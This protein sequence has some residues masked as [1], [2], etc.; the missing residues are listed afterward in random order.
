MQSVDKQELFVNKIIP[1]VFISL[2]QC[3]GYNF[4]YE[5][6]FLE[7]RKRDIYDSKV[8]DSREFMQD[9]ADSMNLALN[10]LFS[11]NLKPQYI[12]PLHYVVLPYRSFD[13]AVE[14]YLSLEDDSKVIIEVYNKSG[15]LHRSESDRKSRLHTLL[16]LV[17]EYL[18]ECNTGLADITNGIA[19][20]EVTT[21]SLSSEIEDRYIGFS[22]IYELGEAMQGHL[23]DLIMENID[24]LQMKCSY[25]SEDCI[26]ISFADCPDD[27]VLCIM[28]NVVNYTFRAFIMLGDKYMDVV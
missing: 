21:V 9:I 25:I 19:S 22:W 1:D 24:R 14:Y 12:S 4:S 18:E 11:K 2:S 17:Y 27:I 28:T 26:Q 13:S 20:V 6:K 7:E 23:Y 16:R 10:R 5:I 15:C 8:S 3:K